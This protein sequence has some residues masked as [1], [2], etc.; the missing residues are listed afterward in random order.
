MPLLGLVFQE[1]WPNCHPAGDGVECVC[2]WLAASEG[3]MSQKHLQ[4]C[5]L[6][7]GQ[8]ASLSHLAS[9]LSFFSASPSLSTIPTPIIS[10]WA[11]SLFP[12]KGDRNQTSALSSHAERVNEWKWSGSERVHEQ[13]PIWRCT[14]ARPFDLMAVSATFWRPIPPCHNTDKQRTCFRMTC[15]Y[16]A[17]TFSQK[18]PALFWFVRLYANTLICVKRY[19]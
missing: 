15:S 13:R 8:S 18:K 19:P 17:G 4:G 1:M 3:A 7:R 10:R 2:G 16:K 12:S 5:Y 11:R 9:F 6:L 14:P